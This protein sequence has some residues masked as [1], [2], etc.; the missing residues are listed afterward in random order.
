MYE[1]AK[2]FLN[3]YKNHLAKIKT[4][5]DEV[6][7]LYDKLGAKSIGYE[8]DGSSHVPSGEDRTTHIHCC[9]N[10][11][12]KDI[13]EEMVRSKE[14]MHKVAKKIRELDNDIYV[15]IL[16]DFYIQRKGFESIAIE[17]GYHYMY[18]L[19]LHGKALK[20][21]ENIL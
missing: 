19:S 2:K 20:E 3:S 7:R 18:T 5:E 13:Q 15:K 8:S 16:Y 21:I 4:M 11:I 6:E 17:L 1:K 12:E 10:D 14:T 9:I